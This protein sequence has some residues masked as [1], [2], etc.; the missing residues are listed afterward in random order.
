LNNLNNTQSNNLTSTEEETSDMMDF[1]L[2]PK[3]KSLSRLPLGNPTA[4]STSQS[5][6]DTLNSVSHKMSQ[7]KATLENI[8][9]RGTAAT[10]T[11]S[12]SI[13][14]LANEIN[15]TINTTSFNG[16]TVFGSDGKDISFSIGNGS[17]ITLAAQ[18]LNMSTADIDLHS[19]EGI[20]S[21]LEA[22]SDSLAN[23][24]ELENTMETQVNR[25]SNA[26]QIL[27]PEESSEPNQNA[28]ILLASLAAEESADT[29]EYLYEMD[30]TEEPKRV[31]SLL[32]STM[33]N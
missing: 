7:M 24:Q 18:D 29:M 31:A 33:T 1:L 23:V 4:V 11:E 14:S 2:K 28:A 3:S 20:N 8:K 25:L 30:D 13:L 26:S 19:T 17:M 16:N 22:T 6:Q 9:E 5:M 15:D 21:V 27:E 32:S 12:A 10:E